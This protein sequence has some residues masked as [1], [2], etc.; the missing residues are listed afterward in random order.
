[1]CTIA[2]G[3][4]AAPIYVMFVFHIVFGKRVPGLPDFVD[5]IEL[6]IPEGLSMVGFD[7]TLSGSA[8][9]WDDYVVGEKVR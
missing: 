5:A 9:L 3:F 2:L 6:V 4:E 1:M 8:M 7:A